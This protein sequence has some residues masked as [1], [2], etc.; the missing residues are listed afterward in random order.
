MGSGMNG[1]PYIHTTLFNDFFNTYGGLSGFDM[2]DLVST[3]GG[4]DDFQKAARSLVAAYLNS[5]WGMNYPYTTGELD[6][7]WTDAVNNGTFQALHEELDAANNSQVD[8]D[9]DGVTEHL[10]PISAGGW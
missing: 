2:F 7:M 4:P 5:S 10:C 6:A 9:G 3:G 8:T 1:N